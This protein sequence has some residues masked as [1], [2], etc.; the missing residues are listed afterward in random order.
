MVARRPTPAGSPLLTLFAEHS[1][2][3]WPACGEPWPP[4][5][6]GALAGCNAEWQVARCDT[7]RN[8]LLGL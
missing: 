3:V 4:P 2:G 7:C 1:Q 6:R 8:W 5:A